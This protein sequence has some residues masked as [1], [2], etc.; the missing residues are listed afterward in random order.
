[1][2]RLPDPLSRAAQEAVQRLGARLADLMAAAYFATTAITGFVWALSPWLVFAALATGMAALVSA[3]ARGWLTTQTMRVKAFVAG[4]EEGPPGFLYLETPQVYTRERLVNDRFNQANWLHAQLART[5]KESFTESFARP[6]SA[7]EEIRRLALSLGAGGPV[8]KAA[9]SESEEADGGQADPRSPEQLLLDRLALFEKVDGY[10]TALRSELMDVQLDDGH[11]LDGNTLYRLNFNAVVSPFSDRRSYPGSALFLIRATKPDTNRKDKQLQQDNEE[12]L[13]QWQR[14][15]QAFLT[16][17]LEQKLEDFERQSALL[18]PTDPKEDLALGWFMRT[19]LIETF[20]EYLNAFP[21]NAEWYL[22]TCDRNG[23]ENATKQELERLRNCRIDELA[24]L[25]GFEYRTSEPSPDMDPDKAA[26]FRRA[27]ELA[28][29]VNLAQWPK[30]G[31][32]SY[33]QRCASDRTQAYRDQNNGTDNRISDPGAP[34]PSGPQQEGAAQT[35]SS[36]GQTDETAPVAPSEV[37][38]AGTRA[39]PART[40]ADA[41]DPNANSSDDEQPATPATTD[42]IVAQAEDEKQSAAPSTDKLG[43]IIFRECL[44]DYKDPYRLRALARLLSVTEDLKNR[45]QQASA[46]A[47]KYQFPPIYEETLPKTREAARETIV[48]LLAR[49]G[50]VLPKGSPDDESGESGESG[51]SDEEAVK[52][53]LKGLKDEI[54][55]LIAKN[56]KLSELSPICEALQ[57]KPDPRETAIEYARC[58]FLYSQAAS[59]RGLLAEFIVARVNGDLK[60]FYDDTQPALNEFLTV[61]TDGC[62][63]NG[64]SIRVD[65]KKESSNSEDSSESLAE[66]LVR[67]LDERTN[68]LS[69]Y[70]IA[71]RSETVIRRA[72]D[73][74]DLSIGLAGP[75]GRA[76]AG[77]SR[78]QQAAYAEAVVLGFGSTPRQEEGKSEPAKEVVFGWT[79][80]PQKAPSGVWSSSYHRLSA[81][82]SV[83]S[84]WKRLD[85]DIQACWLGSQAARDHGDI[86]FDNPSRICETVYGKNGPD[87]ETS[88]GGAGH[89]KR[90]VRIQL[91]RSIDEVTARFNFDLVKA[92]YFDPTWKRANQDVSNSVMAG[93]PAHIALAGERLWRG[94]VVTIDGQPADR[95]IVLPDMK[96]VIAEFKCVR[97]PPG[98]VVS[99][100]ATLT[101]WTA[102]GRTAPMTIGIDAFEPESGEKPCYWGET[103]AAGDG[104]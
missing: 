68:G 104:G 34:K 26:G 85:L 30:S 1:M 57:D 29:L 28:H 11:D 47:D 43:G 48:G 6:A 84:W 59:L 95:I 98:S 46:E 5:E 15:M 54:Y 33:N 19:Q 49:F 44:V 32:G 51:E 24:R 78:R 74:E 42:A 53:T 25:A 10:R 22:K 69:V 4:E 100:R 60:Q 40:S 36:S 58:R 81:V 7:T 16:R 21:G 27:I 67:R 61:E 3:D 50:D 77:R 89:F 96:G 56:G 90:E 62:E 92:P 82:I 45:H 66:N 41:A 99:P 103:R 64:C 65:L 86:L 23:N 38:D 71:P 101:V 70:E 83:P 35:D 52:L 18:N 20:L 73:G 76:S 37:K 9:E 93:R 55:V 72:S 91:P 12:L 88:S 2:S 17:V 94:T 63:L 13:Q 75:S 87:S 102:E 97:P 8:T 31:P 39:S 14:E 79:V 80:R